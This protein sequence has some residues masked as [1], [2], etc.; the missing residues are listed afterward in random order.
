MARNWTTLDFL[1]LYHISTSHGGPDTLPSP[2]RWAKLRADEAGRVIRERCKDTANVIIGD[3][4]FDR[5]EERTI[6]SEDVYWILENG[7]VDGDPI[8]EKGSGRW[9]S[10]NGCRVSEKP[11]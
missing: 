11:E 2:L 6:T 3:H 5:I 7:H 1:R 9:L 10:S 8:K 4:A